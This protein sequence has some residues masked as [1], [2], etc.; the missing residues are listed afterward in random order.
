[1]P[2]ALSFAPLFLILNGR[3]CNNNNLQGHR[4]GKRQVIEKKK[5]EKAIANYSLL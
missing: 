5:T 2:N 3:R 1:M 4:E